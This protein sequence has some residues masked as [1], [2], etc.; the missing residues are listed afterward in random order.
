M[1]IEE[2]AAPRPPF[3]AWLLTQ[4]DRGGLVGQLSAG[5]AVDRRFPKNGDPGDVRAHLTAMQ[6]DGDIFAALD[7]AETDWMCY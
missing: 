2:S 7:D 6:A 4:K 5:A 1:D 3:G